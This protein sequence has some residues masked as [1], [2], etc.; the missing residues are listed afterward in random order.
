MKPLYEYLIL[1]EP[2][3]LLCKYMAEDVENG[4]Y[5]P[6]NYPAV[7]YVVY[8]HWLTYTVHK[9]EPFFKDHVMKDIVKL[10][11]ILEA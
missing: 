11:K 2:D 1:I 6:I 7:L 10:F 8:M 4:V 3:R 5:N 9:E